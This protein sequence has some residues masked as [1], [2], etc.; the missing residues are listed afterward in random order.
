MARTMRRG[1]L[2]VFWLHTAL[3]TRSEAIGQDSQ[4]QHLMLVVHRKSEFIDAARPNTSRATTPSK[5]RV[6]TAVIGIR[7]ENFGEPARPG[8]HIV[9]LEQP[10]RNGWVSLGAVMP[11]GTRARELKA[12]AVSLRSIG[13]DNRKTQ[14]LPELILIQDYLTAI[15][16]ARRANRDLLTYSAYF[17]KLY[18]VAEKLQNRP[19]VA[20]GATSNQLAAARKH[21]SQGHRTIACCE[22]TTFISALQVALSKPFRRIL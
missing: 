22:I 1:F 19:V 4:D 15:K 20:T 6:G 14:S 12:T 3:F 9:T 5:V 7:R 13:S 11:F 17:D 16:Y 10:P 8:W 2:V 21:Y 18:D